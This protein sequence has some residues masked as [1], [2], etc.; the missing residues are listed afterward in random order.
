MDKKELNDLE[1]DSYIFIM[2]FE[3][4]ITIMIDSRIWM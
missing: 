3:M 4:I 1:L 2:I